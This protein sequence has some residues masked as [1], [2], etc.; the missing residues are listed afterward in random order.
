MIGNLSGWELITLV[1][2]ALFI[3][4]PER[5][6]KAVSDGMRFLRGLRAMARKATA[7]L[8]REL[9]TEVTLEDLHP[10]TFIRKHVLSEEEQAAIRR[11]LDDLARDVR[12]IGSDARRAVESVDPGPG[13]SPRP[14]IGARPRP[15]TSR[16]RPDGPPATDPDAT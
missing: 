13:T 8:S 7:D 3:F 5:L 1:L 4:G 15:G 10:K 6:P 11:P 16:R 14:A 2:L 12:G 9:G